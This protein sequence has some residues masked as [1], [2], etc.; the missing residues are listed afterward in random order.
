MAS[1]GE[2]FRTY[3]LT[4][5][6]ITDIV[7]TRVY[8]N[9][10]PQGQALPYLWFRRGTTDDSEG[11]TL[12][13]SQGGSE[14]FR[15]TFD[16]ECV[17]DETALDNVELLADAIKALNTE[18]GTF[19]DGTVQGLFVDDHSDNYQPTND[20]GD[21]GRHIATAEVQVVGYEE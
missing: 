13:K 12:D 20:N 18:T 11:L 10:V 3:I 16:V 21:E 1:I 17:G 5:T 4:K 19:G 15:E 14:Q 8:Q 9:K 7:S 6:A 2:S